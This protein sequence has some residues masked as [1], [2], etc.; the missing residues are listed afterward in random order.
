MRTRSKTTLQQTCQEMKTSSVII[1]E[2]DEE[3]QPQK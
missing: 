1:K 2:E 3:E